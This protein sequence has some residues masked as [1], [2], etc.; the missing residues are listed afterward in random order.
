MDKKIGELF[1]IQRGD[2][3]LNPT[4]VSIANYFL[5]TG[6]VWLD[7][8]DVCGVIR[9]ATRYKISKNDVVFCADPIAYLLLSMVKQ[10]AIRTSIFVSLEMFEYQ[11][12]NCSIRNILRNLIF[13]LL[14][15]FALFFSKKIIFSNELRKNFYINKYSFLRRKKFV[16][17]ENYFFLIP[18]KGLINIDSAIVRKVMN[19]R[20]RVSCLLIYSGSIDLKYR[21]ILPIILAVQ[22]VS[23]VG[24][25]I[26]GSPNGIID[27]VHGSNNVVC[28]GALNR[29]T[30]FEVY[31]YCDFGVM[32]YSNEI[33]NTRFCA[34]IKLYEYLYFGLKI[35][36]NRNIA[37]MNKKEFIEFYFDGKESLVE[38]LQN[39]TKEKILKNSRRY[40][41][42]TIFTTAMQ[43]L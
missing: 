22:E 20:N 30:L 27:D 12:D 43:A 15:L 18:D 40:E 39:M 38:Y 1:I 19:I 26:A 3:F 42:T 8:S 14:H 41:F 29:G 21:D 9:F 5:A 13:R 34:P 28:L 2:P 11:V 4:L 7:F 35:I 33:L 24:F 32:A 6:V 23:N 36:S 16:V 25:I 17:L 10:R 37:M 31:K